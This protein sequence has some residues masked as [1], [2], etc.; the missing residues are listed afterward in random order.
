MP[1]A[2]GR[3]R[4][5]NTSSGR[6]R[7]ISCTLPRSSGVGRGL[8]TCSRIS[9]THTFEGI[10][11]RPRRRAS[12]HCL[13]SGAPAA[14]SPSD[15]AVPNV[16][17]SPPHW[18]RGN[19][20]HGG[21]CNALHLLVGCLAPTACC[22]LAGRLLRQP[23][24]AELPRGLSGHT[25]ALPHSSLACPIARTG[26]LGCA[27][28]LAHRRPRRPRR[29]LRRCPL[30]PRCLRKALM[31]QTGWQ[32][33]ALRV[34]SGGR[35]GDLRHGEL[36]GPG[37]LRALACQS[38][39]AVLGPTR[40]LR[41]VRPP[42][43][44]LRRAP[45]DHRLSLPLRRR[46][47]RDTQRRGPGRPVWQLRQGR[48]MGRSLHPLRG[49]RGGEVHMDVG[50]RRRDQGRHASHHHCS[51]RE[52]SHAK[53]WRRQRNA[54]RCT[55]NRA[56]LAA[57]LPHIGKPRF[58]VPSAVRHPRAQ[59]GHDLRLADRRLGPRSEARCARPQRPRHAGTRGGRGRGQ[60]HP[61][62]C[63]SRGGARASSC[64]QCTN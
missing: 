41:E 8:T 28:T 61:G 47:P 42:L 2:P 17:G 11:H 4:N 21:L 25:A 54:R 23:S 18:L 63:R 44:R 22:R 29:Q 16:T 3:P 31:V 60:R 40:L 14:N 58:L 37:G 62:C 51:A 9:R 36:S 53:D 52:G 64:C 56:A 32:P 46:L 5:N 20:L 10:I 43:R 55:P 49:I 19:V 38:L 12:L 59:S 57:C 6:W 26:A 50:W 13:A 33:P 1:G 45:H 35:G 30:R 39:G 7:H 34:W 48:P 24:T 15:L 27:R